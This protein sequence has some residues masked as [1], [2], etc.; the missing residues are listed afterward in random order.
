MRCI[1][2]IHLVELLKLE[3]LKLYQF[4]L[5]NM[6]YSAVTTEDVHELA[7]KYFGQQGGSE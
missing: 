4:G 7:Q 2:T 6:W 3:V 5:T 1:Y